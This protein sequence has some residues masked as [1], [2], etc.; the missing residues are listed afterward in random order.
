MITE[1]ERL[2]REKMVKEA[3]ANVR[4]EGGNLGS[5]A[6][7]VYDEFIAGK[8]DFDEC[9]QKIFQAAIIDLKE[10]SKKLDK[11]FPSDCD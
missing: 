1:Q 6:L 4:L 9:K 10:L 8:F 2:E 11:E 3:L 5:H 7:L